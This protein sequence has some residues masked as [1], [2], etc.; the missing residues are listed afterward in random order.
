[1]K[2]SQKNVKKKV[3]PKASDDINNTSDDTE[4]VDEISILTSK[5][6]RMFR[7]QERKRKDKRFRTK[8][9]KEQDERI[10]CYGCKKPVH[11][12][13]EC[14]NQVEEKQ[15]KEKKKK[16]FKKKKSLMLTLENLDLSSSDSEE[17]TN[18]CHM[19]NVVD[20]SMLEDLDNDVDFTGIYSLR[21]ADQEAISNNGMI[22]F[23]YKTMRRNYKNSCK[24]IEL[25][26]LREN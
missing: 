14:P 21:L 4:S 8:D 6:K 12:K 3:P 2:S 18:I 7:K 24:E 16:L 13:S 10:V 5:I 20:N 11:F 9:G 23:A 26:Q 15:E 22:A 25:M 17:E 1:M 19:A